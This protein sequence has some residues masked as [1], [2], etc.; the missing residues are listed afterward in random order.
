[1]REAI[2]HH[3][4]KRVYY[5]VDFANFIGTEDL[6]PARTFENEK[7]KGDGLFERFDDLSYM[8]NSTDWL[9]NERSINWLFP[10]TESQPTGGVSGLLRNARMRVD[11]TTLIEGAETNEK[12]WH[13]YGQGYGN[14]TTSFD[15]NG[16][17]QK[18]SN[19]VEGFDAKPITDERVKGLIDMLD[20]CAA[21]GIEFI[22]FVPALPEFSLISMKKTYTGLSSQIR[23][24]VEAHGG[25]YYDFNVADPAFYLPLEEHWA[26]YQHYNYAGGKAFSEAFAKLVNALAA[27][28][29]V[30]GWFTTY[31]KRL[32]Q[33]NRIST[34]AFSERALADGVK[35]SARAFAGSNVKVKYQFQEI[36]RAHV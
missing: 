10:W 32:A 20:L 22:A 5:G 14:Y 31:E 13:Y 26:D 33:I 12:G 30:S 6:Y 35:L 24:A 28:Q 15:Y 8:L 9:F 23:E 1:M 21:N 29:D 16:E 34:V 11:G 17:T 27:G 2:E 3:N 4:L 19:Q 18:N 25:S 36:G 7:W